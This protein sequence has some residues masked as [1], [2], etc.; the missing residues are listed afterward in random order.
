M[1]NIRL[2]DER[3]KELICDCFGDNGETV[4]ITEIAI[5]MRQ[6]LD[7]QIELIAQEAEERA[8]KWSKIGID[9]RTIL[10]NEFA[11]HLRQLE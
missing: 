2:S 5:M 10:F 8:R 3:I 7:E 1:N 11:A 4:D 9:P 6:A